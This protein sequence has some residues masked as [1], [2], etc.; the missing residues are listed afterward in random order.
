LSKVFHK[1]PIRGI[2][3]LLFRVPAGKE[4][5]FEHGLASLVADL[6]VEIIDVDQKLISLINDGF[7][8]EVKRE[9]AIKSYTKMTGK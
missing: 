3:N 2:V 8:S 4:L 1:V 7:N 6:D 5:A 9:S